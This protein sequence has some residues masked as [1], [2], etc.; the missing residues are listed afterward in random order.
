ME[1]RKKTRW[2]E[3]RVLRV[4][5]ASQYSSGSS[6]H[7]DALTADLKAHFSPEQVAER[8]AGLL[9]YVKKDKPGALKPVTDEDIALAVS[10]TVA[11]ETISAEQRHFHARL[12]LLL[13]RLPKR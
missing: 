3:Q 12:R 13:N 10:Q 9:S 4:G 2:G 8:A 7:V 6:R 11:N 1:G 5:F